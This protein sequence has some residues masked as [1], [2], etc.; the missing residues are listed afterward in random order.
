MSDEEQHNLEQKTG[1]QDDL[2]ASYIYVIQARAPISGSGFY[3]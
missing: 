2:V 3:P 1:D